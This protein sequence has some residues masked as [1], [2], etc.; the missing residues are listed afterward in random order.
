MEVEQCQN[1]P[2]LVHGRFLPRDGVES[3]ALQ[4]HGGEGRQKTTFLLRL[5]EHH[6]KPLTRQCEAVSNRFTLEVAHG[7][8]HPTM[9]ITRTRG[10]HAW[11]AGEVTVL[12]RRWNTADRETQERLVT[13][14]YPEL[15]KLAARYLKAERTSP[16]LQRTALV[17]EAYLS[18]V[19]HDNHNWKNRAHFFGAAARV[20]RRIL[21]DHA[22]SRDA[23]KREG[24]RDA[25]SLDDAR[26]VTT[27][28]N[29]DVLALDEA[30]DH[31]E[32]LS[33][34]Q[35]S[36]V[37]LRYFGGLTVEETAEVLAI[38][39]RTVDRD[40]GAARAWLRRCLRS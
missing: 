16:V 12:L 35:A 33:P 22:R 40:W 6:L 38:T 17:H 34:R 25:I 9:A 29:V 37:Q 18:L 7:I 19:G 3:R 24:D 11:S 39:S 10:A 21:V 8:P 28:P 5:D 13:L 32:K 4:V 36:I 1:L 2:Q 23:R 27:E 15:R 31:L 30:L 20:M 26:E 14:I